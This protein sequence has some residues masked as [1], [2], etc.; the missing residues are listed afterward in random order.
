MPLDL[1]SAPSQV[2]YDKE[3]AVVPVSPSPQRLLLP[4]DAAAEQKARLPHAGA[5]HSP[6]S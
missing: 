4:R 2:L 3:L 1:A 6:G 5:A